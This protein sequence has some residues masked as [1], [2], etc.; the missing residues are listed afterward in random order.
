MHSPPGV[1]RDREQCRLDILA[2]LKKMTLGS[3][4]GQGIGGSSEG[5]LS[6]C[7]IQQICALRATCTS[8]CSN[9]LGRS[10]SSLFIRTTKRAAN[11]CY[12]SR[13]PFITVLQQMKPYFQS[14]INESDCSRIM[15]D[16][17]SGLQHWYFYS[18]TPWPSSSSQ[19][20]QFS[21]NKSK[22]H[23]HFFYKGTE[24]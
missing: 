3:V 12:T 16:E 21:T 6:S 10:F 1:C 8:P 14:S 24:R 18:Q 13:V 20:L 7:T 4:P 22:K 2:H 5:A 19:N 15:T 23:L 17:C 11:S 9:R